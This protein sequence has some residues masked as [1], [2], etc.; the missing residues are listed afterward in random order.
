MSVNRTIT[1]IFLVPTLKIPKDD[2]LGN[3]FINAYIKDTL[4]DNQYPVDVV[5]LLFKPTDINKFREFLISEYSRTDDVIDDYDYIGGYVV[6]VYKIRDSIKKDVCLIKHGQ[7]SKTSQE[8]QELF[9]ASVQIKRP[10]GIKTETSLQ[11]RI[12]KKSA[13]LKEYWENK[14][15]QRLSDDQEVWENYDEE[16]EKLNL[17]DLLDNV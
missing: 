6:V 1:T 10:N 7:Y 13:D 12:F 11:V 2:L 15:G 4:Q 14:I 3:G 16:K 5:F 8:F 17:K 9:P